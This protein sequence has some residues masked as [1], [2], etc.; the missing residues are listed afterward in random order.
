MSRSGPFVVYSVDA[1]HR[2]TNKIKQFVWGTAA[3]VLLCSGM[4][5]VQAGP[6]GSAPVDPGSGHPGA[7][8]LFLLSWSGNG[9]SGSALFAAT[10]NGDGSF[11]ATSGAGSVSGAPNSGFL[12][13]FPTTG[14]AFSPSGFFIF[15]DLIYPGQPAVVDVDGLLFNLP[16]NLEVNLFN[17]GSPNNPQYLYYDN[18]GFNVP[19]Q[20]EVTAVPEPASLALLGM[21]ILGMCG[22]G[23]RRARKSAANGM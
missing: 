4:A 8:P 9:V 19:V 18:T 2:R 3:L 16:N 22:Y 13:L 23:M 21:G 14:P 17:N 10:D 6:I 12:T 11:L 7:D 15:N 20:M 5:P 1:P